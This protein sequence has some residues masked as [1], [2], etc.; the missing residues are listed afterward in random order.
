M[1]TRRHICEGKTQVLENR[2]VT[3]EEWAHDSNLSVL[4]AGQE[5]SRRQFLQTSAAGVLFTALGIGRVAEVFAAENTT[6]STGITP[7]T[8]N[9]PQSAL[10]DLKRRLDMTRWPNRQT[11]SDWSQGVPLDKAR[12][13]IEYWRTQYDWRRAEKKINGFA[14][15]R[16]EIDGLGIHF[17]HARSQHEDA[18]PVILTHG[19][20]GSIIEFLDVIDPL[21]N[22]TAYGG[23]PGDAFHVILPSLPGFGFSDQPADAGWDVLRIA[24]AWIVLMQRLGCKRWVAQGGDW[25]AAVTTALG[26]LKPPGL[27]GIHLNFQFVFPEK[28]P[29][30]GLSAEEQRAVTALTEFLNDGN[31]YFKEQ[32]T[33]PQTIGYAL[34][35]SPSGQAAWIYEK[36]QAWTDCN[37]DPE[38]VLT[39]EQM[40]DNISLYWLTGTA[41]SSA[42]IYWENRTGSPSQ[43]GIDIPVAVSV[44]PHEIWRTPR[45]WAEKDYSQLIYWHELDRGGHF[46][47]FE[48]PE[49][50]TQELRNGFKKLR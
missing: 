2:I 43:G 35:D 45:S 22:P 12:A 34:A 47:A 37:G 5:V 39:K 28:M 41:A 26:K 7:F 10:D 6:S 44:F 30:E 17:I 18:L 14:Q 3:R 25:G 48:Q 11:V 20:P 9:I 46:A 16:T 19:W 27:A 36:F 42:R 21:T 32:A 50:F 13:L 29:T 40:L 23:K 33:R 1:R 31:G 15:Y 38:N 8:I 24:K 4:P 49:L